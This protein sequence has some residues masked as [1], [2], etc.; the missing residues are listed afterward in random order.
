MINDYFHNIFLPS[1]KNLSRPLSKSYGDVVERK[2]GRF[3]IIPPKHIHK[4]IYEILKESEKFAIYNKM[5][6]DEIKR[7]TGEDVVEKMCLLPIQPGMGLLNGDYHRDI[8]VKSQNDFT[9]K[10]FYITH[11]IYLD[12]ISS[13]EFCIN[14]QNN[15]NNNA[16]IYSKYISEPKSG[17]DII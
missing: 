9:S 14:S 2:L 17:T 11:L 8:F 6:R 4:Q 12:D 15:P 5:A 10:P 16:D 1:L 3:E 13:T 7:Y